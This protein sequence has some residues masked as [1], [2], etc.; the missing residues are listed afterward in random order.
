MFEK[1]LIGALGLAVALIGGH[2][3]VRFVLWKFGKG[4]TAR[5]DNSWRII[6][7]LD[8]I[9]W[10][11]KS[12]HEL[13]DGSSS[14]WEGRAPH[15]LIGVCER[16]FFTI[17][18]GFSGVGI[19]AGTIIA[20]LAIKAALDWPRRTTKV[21]SGEKRDRQGPPPISASSN[22]SKISTL[23]KGN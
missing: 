5:P 16:L 20:W 14:R 4:S 21:C 17:V 9:H 12:N 23:L 1:Y 6:F 13:N 19:G 15:W 22:L 7:T 18:V 2:V 11:P 8:H 3:C 10:S